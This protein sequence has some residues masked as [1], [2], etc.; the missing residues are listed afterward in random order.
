[1]GICVFLRRNRAHSGDSIFL[2]KENSHTLLYHLT[3]ILVNA[4]VLI[5]NYFFIKTCCFTS[6]PIIEY[7]SNVA[8]FIGG[9][10]LFLIINL[11][12]EKTVKFFMILEHEF[13]HLI[14]A[15]LTFNKI[16]ALNINLKKGGYVKIEGSNF[17]I[18][19]AP[20]VFPLTMLIF[21][22]LKFVVIEPLG[23]PVYLMIGLFELFYIFRLMG[24]IHSG[25][26][27]FQI[28]GKIYSFISVINFNI[29]VQS[30]LLIIT[31]AD[32]LEYH[33]LFR[34]TWNNLQAAVTVVFQT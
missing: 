8:L 15:L 14:A 6:H 30:Y 4:I 18:A 32:C 21:I 3:I 27:D 25:Q 24:E 12:S 5:Y 7:N 2:M 26:T 17:F 16:H 1:M 33:I 34:E 11:F 29:L 28:I 23:K 22:G 9:A 10:I 19:I 13:T 31:L 20:Y